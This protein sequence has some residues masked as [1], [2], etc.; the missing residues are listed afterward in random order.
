MS[1]RSFVAGALAGIA[2]AGLASVSLAGGSSPWE[3]G[4]HDIGI[5]TSADGEIV[6]V[7]SVRGF[8]KS[9]NGGET[10]KEMQ[11]R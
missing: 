4:T 7:V 8:F 3:V 6:Y 10:W 11:F 1:I 2:V 9:S 5:A